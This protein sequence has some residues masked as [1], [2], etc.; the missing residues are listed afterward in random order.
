MVVDTLFL[1]RLYLFSVI[2]VSNRQIVL[3][4][5]TANP[6]TIWL[7]TVVRCGFSSLENIP[8]VMVSDRDGIYGEWF[9]NFLDN[10]FDI[11]LIRTPPRTPNCNAFI[12][13]W[14]RSIREEALDHCL[15]FGKKDLRKVVGEYID[16]YNHHRPHQGISQNSPLKNHEPKKLNFSVP[17]FV[18]KK[19]VDGII[20][21][22]ELAA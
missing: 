20:T 12:E 1:K 11:K 2:D 15:V 5:I 14:H 16:Y 9:G 17:K 19:M 22:F 3:F 7:E 10:S 18:R 21:N 13:R 4:N 6:T 8:K